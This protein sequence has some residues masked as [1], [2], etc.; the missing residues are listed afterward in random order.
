MYT[1]INMCTDRLPYMDVTTGASDTQP[2][3]HLRLL[4]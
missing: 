3:H 2:V 1:C 4:P